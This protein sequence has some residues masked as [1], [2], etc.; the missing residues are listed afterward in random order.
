MLKH[1]LKLILLILFIFA[2]AFFLI[3]I[4]QMLFVSDEYWMINQVLCSM[5]LDNASSQP[6]TND[7]PVIS[8]PASTDLTNPNTKP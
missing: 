8:S 6:T 1:T 4:I 2:I 5:D 7:H 3:K